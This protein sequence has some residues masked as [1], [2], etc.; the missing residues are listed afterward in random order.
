MQVEVAVAGRGRGSAAG[1]R[2]ADAQLVRV[3][4]AR[5]QRQLVTEVARVHQRPRQVSGTLAAA[6]SVIEYTVIQTSVLYYRDDTC[7]WDRNNRSSSLL[8]T[9]T[10]VNASG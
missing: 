10:I 2:A 6:P 9:T 4:R 8:R 3:P 7:C 1:R 5:A